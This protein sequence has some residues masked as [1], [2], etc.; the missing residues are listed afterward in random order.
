VV[1]LR[2]LLTTGAVVGVLCLSACASTS[3]GTPRPATPATPATASATPDGAAPAAMTTLLDISG[4]GTR[5]SI[6]FTTTAEW[7]VDY[8]FDCAAFG[9]AGSFGL[10]E[11]DRLGRLGGFLVND[12]STSGTRTVPRHGDSGVHQIEVRSLCQWTVVVHG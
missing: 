3:A 6:P 4:S 10:A 11:Y 2:N 8:T 12:I 5:M 9:T 7:S 1:S